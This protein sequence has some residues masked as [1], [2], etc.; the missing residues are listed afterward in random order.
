NML[1]QLRQMKMDDLLPKV[2]ETVPLVRV[3]AGCPP[4]VTPTSQIVGAQSVN[5]LVSVEK[6]DDP[7]SNPSTQFKNLVKG[8]YGK[9]PIEIDPDFREKI[10]GD[11]KEVP[12]SSMDYKPQENPI[13]LEDFGGIKLAATEEE[14]LLLELFP[15]VARNYLTNRKEAEV[16]ELKLQ[17]QAEQFELSEKSRKEFHNLS[18]D[19]K[20]ARIIKGLGI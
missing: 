6:G 13:I 9:T 16:A 5:Y 8:I 20:A 12:F 3:E 11:R 4:L 7:Y 10:C 14:E 17:I 15:S 1:A 2:L 18:D 19:D